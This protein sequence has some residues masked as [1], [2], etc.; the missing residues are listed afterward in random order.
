MI[1]KSPTLSLAVAGVSAQTFPLAFLPLTGP[2]GGRNVIKSIQ[3]VANVQVDTDGA[4]T[5]AAGGWANFLQRM[6]IKVPGYTPVDCTGP[7]LRAFD[8]LFKGRQAPIDPTNLAIS[9]ANATRTIRWQVDF[10]PRRSKR[11]WDFCLP[12]DVLRANGDG[13]LQIWTNGASSIGT[14]GGTTVDSISVYLVVDCREEFDVVARPKRELKAFSSANTTD[15]QLP[16]GGAYVRSLFLH[17]YS[18][19]ASGGSD[20]SS[21]TG[22][23]IPAWGMQNLDPQEMRDQL[24]AEGVNDSASTADPFVQTTE[25]AIVIVHPHDD[26]KITDLLTHKADMQVTLTAFSVANTPFCMEA[27]YPADAESMRLELEYAAK[28]GLRARS[29]KTEGKTKKDPAAWGDL[30]RL[31]PNKLS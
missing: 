28:Y 9:Q 25:R 30:G 27:L 14:G 29:V 18:D 12:V 2:R 23:T 26:V 16:V 5:I 11:R 24:I 6:L 10:A 15:H 20:L 31:L 21:C 4:T 19:H 8:Y 13:G 7:Q 1:Y 3:L 22:I 17:K